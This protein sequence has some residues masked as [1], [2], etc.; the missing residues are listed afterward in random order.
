MK[1]T[2]RLLANGNALAFL[3]ATRP[4]AKV[5]PGPVPAACS[6]AV[7][8]TRLSGYGKVCGLTSRWAESLT[9]ILVQPDADFECMGVLMEHSQDV[10]CV[11]WH[12][13]EEVNQ[14]LAITAA[15]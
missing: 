10:K 3:R 5:L 14:F 7:V 11:A 13:T 6:P 15:F 12:P 4:N 1:M 9:Q 8:A 2:E